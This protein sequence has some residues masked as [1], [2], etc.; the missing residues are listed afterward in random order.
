MK[1]TRVCLFP[2]PT[3]VRTFPA[4]SLESGKCGH[5]PQAPVLRMCMIFSK[6]K[7]KSKKTELSLWGLDVAIDYAEL[8][9][10]EAKKVIANGISEERF[11]ELVG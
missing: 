2:Y 11:N 5:R 10:S 8:T 7:Q 6:P 4:I 9:K 3:N 1:V